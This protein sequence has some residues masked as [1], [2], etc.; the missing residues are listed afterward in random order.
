M[1]G[2]EVAGLVFGVLPV[3]VEAVKAY[4]TV[5]DGL[6]TFRH[7]S[8]EVKSISLQLKV[9][10]GI[11]LNECRLLLRLVENEKAAEDMLEDAADR[12]WTSKELNDKLNSVLKDNFELCR[13]IIEETKDIA[14]DMREEL[15]RFDTLEEQK[16][17]VRVFPQTSSLPF[18][19]DVQITY[20]L[21]DEKLKATIKR[22]R[23]AM[24][25]AFDKSKYEKGLNNLRDRNGDL[26]A[27]RQ[28]IGAFQQQTTH[29]AST[30]VRHK[31]LPAR[32][33]SIQNASQKLHEALCSAWCCDDLAHRGHY[34]KLCLDAEVRT[35]VHLDLAISC[36]EPSN[37]G[38]GGWV[39]YLMPFR[40]IA[41]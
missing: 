33:H 1:S 29:A 41:K 2:I 40:A 25:I 24:S 31:A 3:L 12:R 32:F 26:S 16:H 30:L 6:H 9:H 11:F 36:H 35:E 34:A 22:L 27:L 23:G 5:S 7:W 10:N 38:D 37:E 17:K 4:S 20:L 15:K 28:Q 19:L 21:Q 13:N 14:C 18:Q 8:R 39:N